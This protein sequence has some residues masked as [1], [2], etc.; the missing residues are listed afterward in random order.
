VKK[1][2]QKADT[3]ETAGGAEGGLL[4]L[5]R[6]EVRRRDDSKLVGY[7]GWRDLLRAWE[8]A[9]QQEVRRTLFYRFGRASAEVGKGGGHVPPQ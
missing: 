7:L 5:A 6:E 8:Q 3:A 4:G 9:Q 2:A 1:P